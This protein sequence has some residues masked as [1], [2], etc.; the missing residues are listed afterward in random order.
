MLFACE[1]DIKT[2]NTFSQI[3]S[4]PLELARDIEVTYSDSGKIIAYLESPIMTRH[5]EDDSYMEF[6]EGFKIILYDSLMKPKSQI[7]AKYGISFEKKKMMEAKNNVIVTN[8]EKNERL[9]TE[10]L[11]WDRKKMI[12]Y[13]EVFVTITKPDAIIYGDGLMSD[14]DFDHY[15]IKNPTGEFMVNPD[16]E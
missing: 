5:E 11:I 1:N 7:T 8:I 15:K 6:P 14:Q 4:L 3:D 12:I 2:L 9:N 10:H 13:S 16:E